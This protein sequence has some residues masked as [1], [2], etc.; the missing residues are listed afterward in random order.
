MPL[1]D[2]TLQSIKYEADFL[3]AY[4]HRIGAPTNSK[5]PS[6]SHNGENRGSHSGSCS[7]ISMDSI[8]FSAW[9]NL[10][11]A[12]AFSGDQQ[13]TLDD[14]IPGDQ[15]SLSSFLS[16]FHKDCKYTFGSCLQLLP[17]TTGSINKRAEETEELHFK[18]NFK[19]SLVA[20]EPELFF[21]GS[22]RN[23][24]AE[25]AKNKSC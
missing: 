3:R 16:G 22:L 24:A 15:L 13:M 10:R 12:V 20:R 19:K 2:G 8:Y 17:V 5:P 4:G 6:I 7:F 9:E 21:F 23:V 25:S 18:Q 14:E 1:L 11:L